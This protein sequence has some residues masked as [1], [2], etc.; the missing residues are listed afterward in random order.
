MKD[1][2]RDFPGYALR[3]ASVRQMAELATRLAP[4]ELSFTEA[5]ILLM[6]AANPGTTL[7]AMGK[8]LDIKRANMTPLVARIE[9]RGLVERTPIN[10][11]SQGLSLSLKGLALHQKLIEVISDFEESL[12]ER[13]PEHLRPSLLPILKALWEG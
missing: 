8:I 2:L 13:V 6:I 10:G 12:C 11:R 9:S 1:P 4:L 7:S 5:S 3:R